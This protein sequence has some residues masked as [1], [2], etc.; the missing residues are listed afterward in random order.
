MGG[1]RHPPTAAPPQ[2]SP[3]CVSEI[4]GQ[5]THLGSRPQDSVIRIYPR[6]EHWVASPRGQHS[7][8][9][10]FPEMDHVRGGEAG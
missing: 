8:V 2:G 7:V 5:E 4:S 9:V 1:F 6:G 3:K 10:L